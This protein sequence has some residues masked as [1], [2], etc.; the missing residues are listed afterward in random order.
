MKIPRI[1]EIQYLKI[2]FGINNFIPFAFEDD[3][4]DGLDIITNILF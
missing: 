4:D 2:N 1:Q 3:D